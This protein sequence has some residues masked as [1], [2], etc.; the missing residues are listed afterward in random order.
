MS[1]VVMS[2]LFSFVG[3][4]MFIRGV[5]MTTDNVEVEIP[6]LVVWL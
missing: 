3:L 2:I 4:E 5:A 6:D 1:S